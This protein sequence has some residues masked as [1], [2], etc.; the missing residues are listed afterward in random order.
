MV[1]SPAL[2]G[3]CCQTIQRAI[4]EKCLLQSPTA[5][6]HKAYT[7]LLVC[8]CP[9]QHATLVWRDCEWMVTTPVSGGGSSKG[10]IPTTLTWQGPGYGT[11][12]VFQPPSMHPRT[13]CTCL[14]TSSSCSVSVINHDRVGQSKSRQGFFSGDYL[15]PSPSL[16]CSLKDPLK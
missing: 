5:A 2:A 11:A 4:G 3:P 8:Q 13:M 12:H 10:L 16:S 15:R 14:Q 6:C 1:V 7:G 9:P